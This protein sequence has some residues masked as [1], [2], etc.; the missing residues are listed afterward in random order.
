M[1]GCY[2]PVGATKCPSK[3][4]EQMVRP[5]ISAP[6]REKITQEAA[7][8]CGYCLTV[9]E[10]TAMPMHIEHIIPIAAGGLTVEE[11]LW[12]ACPLC[13][14]YKGTQ[15]HASDPQTEDLVPLFNPRQQQWRDHFQWDETGIQVFGKTACGRATIIALKLNND[16]LLRARRRWVLAGW[17]PPDH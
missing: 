14:G 2:W 12:L 16:F 11:N 6:L 5:Y 9:Q 1:H 10:Y 7:Y 13:N 15:T 17:H 3:T 4:P 8:R